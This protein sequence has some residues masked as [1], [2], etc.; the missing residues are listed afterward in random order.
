VNIDRLTIDQSAV[1]A[2][3]RDDQ[4]Q[5]YVLMALALGVPVWLP[6]EQHWQLQGDRRR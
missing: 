1:P 4:P 3:G 6:R 5:A 2:N